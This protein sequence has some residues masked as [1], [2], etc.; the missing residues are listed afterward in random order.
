MGILGFCGSGIVNFLDILQ[1]CTALL[2]YRKK[3]SVS[4]ADKLS[5]FR[6]LRVDFF[7]EGVN[8]VDILA[9]RNTQGPGEC[10]YHQTALFINMIKGR[11]V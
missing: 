6:N 11:A 4:F 10:V 5:E 3:E 2:L 9:L 1:G 7:G 8:Y